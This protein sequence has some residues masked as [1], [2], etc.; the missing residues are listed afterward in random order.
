LIC[1]ESIEVTL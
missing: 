1:F